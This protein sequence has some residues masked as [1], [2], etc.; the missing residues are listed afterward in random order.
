MKH[1]LK[2]DENFSLGFLS[3]FSKCYNKWDSSE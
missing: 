3:V 1:I 2:R